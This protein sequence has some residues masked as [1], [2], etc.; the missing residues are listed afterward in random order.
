MAFLDK[1]QRLVAE[2]KRRRNESKEVCAYSQKI[3]GFEV[4][5]PVRVQFTM[6]YSQEVYKDC[7]FYIAA[8][9]EQVY[10]EYSEVWVYNVQDN[11][12]VFFL[13]DEVTILVE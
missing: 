7:D 4:G 11:H 1:M 8:L 12:L 2:E 5:K 10:P 6:P 3:G 13:W 9:S